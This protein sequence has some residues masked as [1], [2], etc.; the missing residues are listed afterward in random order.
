MKKEN[1]AI[2]FL[3]G[4]ACI[5]VV[6]N[7]YHWSGVGGDVTYALSHFG[8]PIFFL[9]SGYYLYSGDLT[10]NKL[11]WKIKHI[12]H[13]LV[14]HISL[15]I[16][17]FIT[18]RIILL[19]NVIPK[20]VV[21]KDIL[22]Y[23]SLNSFKG[24]LLWSKSLFGTGQ[25]FLIAL[26]E[27]YGICWVIYK[28]QA[29]KPIE[30][31]GIWI[32]T[33]LFIIHI[34]VRILLLKTGFTELLGES[35]AES[36]F[37]RNVWTDALPFMFIGIWL[38]VNEVPE[39]IAQKKKWLL[40]VS[41][42]S[43]IVSVGE[44]YLTSAFLGVIKVNSVLYIG[45]IIS[46]ISAFVWAICYP[47]GLSGWISKAIEYIGKNL[48][49]TVYFIHVIVATYLQHFVIDG[50]KLAFPII[51]IISTIIIS[52]IIFRMKKVITQNST[53]DFLYLMAIAICLS[54]LILPVG[55]EWRML[56]KVTDAGTSSIQDEFKG[57]NQSTLLVTA[58]DN[59]GVT[60]DAVEMPVVQFIGGGINRTLI[61]NGTEQSYNITYVNGRTMD[62]EISDGI[63]QIR[64][65]AK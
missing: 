24:C 10:L 26:L 38:R 61:V 17:D 64:V 60:V 65:W 2:S 27:G 50:T 53:F 42:L 45:T 16:L 34:P 29:Q 40:I 22:S 20:D 30:K 46:V 43:L 4:I 13:L 25:W 3:K 33:S 31:Q 28:L 32:A 52:D 55:S 5:F 8:V 21:V 47:D 56:V 44:Y 62:F 15:F 58:Q 11:P 49:M 59:N 6:L 35:V 41:L 12:A 7:H 14:F 54:L 9:I 23:F 18:E 1:Y 19:G 63:R 39:R 48:S 36:A 37:V 51:V 57:D